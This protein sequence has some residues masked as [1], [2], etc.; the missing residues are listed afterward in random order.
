[1]RYGVGIFTLFL[2][3]VI[4]STSQIAK[5]AHLNVNCDKKESIHRAL[6]FLSEINPQGPNT[7]TVSGSCKENL[8]I[9]SINRLTLI[10][11][12]GASVT[13]VSDGNAP[14]I[15]IE[16]SQSVTLQGFIFNGGSSGVACGSASVCYLTSNTVQG[17]GEGVTVYSGSHAILASNTIQNSFGR[18]STIKQGSQML[19]SNDIFQGN[20]GQGV[21]TIAGA[22]FEAANSSFLNN[23][24]GIEVATNSTLRLISCTVS[25][26]TADGILI[27]ASATAQFNDYNGPTTISGNGGDGVYL[28][29]LSFAYFDLTDI[30]T[31]NSSGLDI[32][33]SPQFPVT[34]GALALTGGTVT[35]CLEPVGPAQAKVTK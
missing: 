8:V 26:N 27:L 20:G 5:A 10:A 17:A 30:V 6:T 32:H 25:G 33:C 1:M 9:Q 14:V 18:G 22:Y 31:G 21:T 11:E 13:D 23:H 3:C 7:I 4:G 16:D 29:D 28:E 15:D 2:L 34:H 35:N 19:S 12:K 24:V